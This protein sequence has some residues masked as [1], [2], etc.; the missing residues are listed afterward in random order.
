[1]ALC[2]PLLELFTGFGPIF[3]RQFSSNTAGSKFGASRPLHRLETL[4]V[5]EIDDRVRGLSGFVFF[6]KK[7]V[8][9][10]FAATASSP[11]YLFLFV[12][13]L[14]TVEIATYP[15]RAVSSCGGACDRAPDPG[16]PRSPSSC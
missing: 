2:R 12:S 7:T 6:H 8:V 1:M 3:Y 14:C 10:S 15:A 16:R 5:F 13:S 9:V 4:T 11:L